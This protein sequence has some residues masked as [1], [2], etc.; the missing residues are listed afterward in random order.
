[1]WTALLLMSVSCIMLIIP[2]TRKNETILAVT[3]VALFVGTW[4]DKGLGL[5]TGGFVP[6]TLHRI[7]DYVPTVPEVLISTG[8]FGVGL[9][10]LTILLKL[11][12]E[13]RRE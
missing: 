10:V 13:V 4:I 6:T 1:M 5:V 8:I 9:L 11:V 12:V 7:Q 3:C 2:A